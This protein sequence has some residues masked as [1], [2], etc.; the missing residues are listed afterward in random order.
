[1]R[2]ATKVLLFSALAPVSAYLGGC[3]GN[4]NPSSTIDA[5]FQGA[6][7][8]FNADGGNNNNGADAT[9]DVAA[10]AGPPS[11]TLSTEPV[12]FGPADCGSTPSAKMYSI[13]N[14]GPVAVTWSATVTAPF[15][16][17]TPTTPSGTVAAGQTIPVAIGVGP[18]PTTSQAGVAITG[19]LTITTDVPGFTS[20][21]VP[22]KVTPQGGSL[23]LKPAMLGFGQQQIN[24]TS[25]P[26]LAFTLANVGNAPVSVA[27][28][29]PTDAEFAVSGAGSIAAG[30]TLAN[31]SATFTPAS[32]GDKSGT[33]A[34]NVTGAL[35]A[36][37]APTSLTFGG[38]GVVAPIDIGPSPLD[39][40]VVSCGATGIHQTVT[41]QNGGLVPITYTAVLGLGMTSP[42]TIDSSSGSIAAG[43]SATIT[44]T[45]NAIPVPGNITAGAYDDTLT[46]ATSAAGTTPLA[47]PLQESASGAIIALSMPSTAFGPVQATTAT[48]PFTVTNSGNADAVGLTVAVTGASFGGSFTA[49]DVAT[50]NGGTA[51]G[52][53]TFTA[54]NNAT[55]TGTIDVATTTPL[56]AAAPAAISMTATSEV[57]VITTN[58]TLAVSTTCGSAGT[59]AS[60]TLINSGNAPATVTVTP[61]KGT[62]YSIVS[63][64]TTVPANGKAAIVIQGV[65]GPQGGATTTDSL[66]FTTNEPT[67]PTHTIGVTNAISGATMT[68]TQPAALTE[69]AQCT[70]TPSTF[71]LNNTGNMT[72]SVTTTIPYVSDY[73]CGATESDYFYFTSYI[74]F[75]S[76]GPTSAPPGSLTGSVEASTCACNAGGIGSASITF[77]ATGAICSGA[78]TTLNISSNS[79]ACKMNPTCGG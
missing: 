73:S 54:T 1:M 2:R 13:Q 15:T 57:P 12:D 58:G 75:S 26:A 5:G 69:T 41:I 51:A 14:S 38:T 42:F 22:L 4:S 56:C 70:A 68:V 39:F 23:T 9:A 77:T 62:V 6:D 27:F 21:V 7:G 55:A 3:F 50:A 64:P 34:I 18:I 32:A 79:S 65:A 67:N 53:A 36:S 8:G 28:G 76:S 59:Q 40:G 63:A 20:V 72:A 44:V 11:V 49:T 25:S 45:P 46:I 16:I 33:A 52:N 47:I 60:L 19:T 10:D 74:S 71:S 78:T 17:V 37:A 30:A 35:C 66:V 48:L 29:T 31:A 61:S 24:T 43:L